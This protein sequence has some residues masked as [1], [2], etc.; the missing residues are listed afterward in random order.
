MT[1]T[2]E[3]SRLLLRR[4]MPQDAEKIA[5][6]IGNW[7]VIRWLGRPPYPYTI[8][9][10]VQY[11]QDA[12]NRPWDF[13]IEAH[14]VV[15]A[16]GITDHLGYWL[17]KPHWGKG[18]ATEATSALLD[19]YFAGTEAEDVVSGYLAGNRA[20]SNTLRKLGFVETGRS[21]ILCQPRREE[22]EHIDMRLTRMD[23]T[24]ARAA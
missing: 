12:A 6:M 10:A 14:D 18:Y 20:S 8:D 7:E 16:V 11:I 19:A 21:T 4:P 24:N 23:W 5:G 1:D 13:I 17:G 2:I 22:V 15:G 3:T 9:D